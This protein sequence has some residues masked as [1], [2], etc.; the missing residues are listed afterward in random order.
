MFNKN[1]F[2]FVYDIVYDIVKYYLMLRLLGFKFLIVFVFL[3]K[4]LIVI[5]LLDYNDF[6]L[7]KFF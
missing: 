4:L 6:I 2:D 1:F 7:R 5:K 3:V